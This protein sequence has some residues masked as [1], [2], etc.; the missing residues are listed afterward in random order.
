[1]LYT[2]S[3]P[4]RNSSEHHLIDLKNQKK[5]N[6]YYLLFSEKID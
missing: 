2:A 6:S 1:M 4:V 5:E 3:D